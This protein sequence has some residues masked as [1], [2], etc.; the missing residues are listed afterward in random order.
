MCDTKYTCCQPVT[1]YRSKN[2]TLYEDKKKCQEADKVWDA[3]QKQKKL[4]QLK[5]DLIEN[6]DV[7]SGLRVLPFDRFYPQ[8]DRYNEEYYQARQGAYNAYEGLARN[9][10]QLRDMLN[11]I[12]E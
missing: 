8:Y 11:A 7:I 4:E 5:K 1:A 2:G 12:Q 10:K 3:Q 9:W 6:F